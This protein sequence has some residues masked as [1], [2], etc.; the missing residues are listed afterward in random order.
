[1]IYS[2]FAKNIVRA[3]RK[4]LRMPALLRLAMIACSSK[5]TIP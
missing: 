5:E 4:I 3:I 1:M 2:K